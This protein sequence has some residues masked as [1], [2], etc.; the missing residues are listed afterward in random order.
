M[1]KL[2]HICGETARETRSQYNMNLDV[3][4][5]RICL[6]A[7]QMEHPPSAPDMCVDIRF[8]PKP[9]HKLYRRIGILEHLHECTSGIIIT[10]DQR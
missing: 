10:Q 4:S 1:R 6:A 8:T 5:K 3:L 2:S 7:F 9:F